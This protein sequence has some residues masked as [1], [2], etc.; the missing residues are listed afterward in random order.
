MGHDH[1]HHHDHLMLGAH[2][3]AGHSEAN[4]RLMRMATYCSV[5][6]ASLL[7]LAKLYA[8][9]RSDSLA[10]LSS[11]TDS[12]FDV[13]S[14]ILNLVALRYALK[15]AD[16]DHRFGHTS[17]E[18]IAGLSQSGFIATS[19]GLIMLQAIER[20]Y[21]PHAITDEWLGLGVSA[22]AMVATIGLVMFQSYVMRKQHSLVIESDRLH[23]AGDVLFNIGVLAAFALDKY[24]GFSWADPAIAIL[25]AIVVLWNT[26]GIAVRAFNNLMDREMADDE[27]AKIREIVTSMPEIIGVHNL[28]TRHSGTRAF[29]QM[30][31]DI[32]ANLN[33]RDAHDIT[34]RLEQA[35]L[36]EFP[37]AE[38]IIHPDP[39]DGP[40]EIIL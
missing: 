34:E 10:M 36:H 30:H 40:R 31:V 15:P 19:M 7:V 39:V 29:M 33:F 21:H 4:T 26:R 27:K 13:L 35:L 17:I 3:H 6:V 8:W 25:I 9:W 38:I 32:D 18:D 20:L 23:Y 5:A 28:K 14:S 16:D 11:V 1:Y 12:F 2:A 37:Q 24:F 22:V